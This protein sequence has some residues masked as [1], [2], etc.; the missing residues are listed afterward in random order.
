MHSLLPLSLG[1]AFH[2]VTD[3]VLLGMYLVL[4]LLLVAQVNRRVLVCLVD[5]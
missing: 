3:L 2:L 5:R 1:L 4:S